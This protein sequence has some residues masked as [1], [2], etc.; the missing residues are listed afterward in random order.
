[1]KPPKKRASLA[2]RPYS[3]CEIPWESCRGQWGGEGRS[4]PG[5]QPTGPGAPAHTP[6]PA[7]SDRVLPPTE[8]RLLA[9]GR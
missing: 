2:P 6:G 4:S 9:S 3:Y 8:S 7:R 5:G 1:M